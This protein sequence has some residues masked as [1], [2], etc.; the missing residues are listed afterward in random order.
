MPACPPRARSTRWTGT[1][2]AKKVVLWWGIFDNQLYAE[3][4]E[5][6]YGPYTPVGGPIPLHRRYKKT[7]TQRRTERIEVLAEK[8][9]LPESVRGGPLP[10][11]IAS[12]PQSATP[13]VLP[14]P[15]QEINFPN[16]IAAKRA[17]ADYLNMPL[18]KP[19]P[20]ELDKL[21]AALAVPCA[22]RMSSTTR[23][24]T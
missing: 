9:A 20:K 12:R 24:S 18:A 15:F 5:H 16:A 11:A 2:P 10:E 8:L 6:R 3:R 22:R 13:F 21:N 1:W 14:D 17:I 23:G 7:K 4:D 19:P